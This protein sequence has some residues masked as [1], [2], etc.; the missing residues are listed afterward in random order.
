MGGGEKS[1][2]AARQDI[3]DERLGFTVESKGQRMCPLVGSRL[4]EWRRRVCLVAQCR[5]VDI[6]VSSVN[7]SVSSLSAMFPIC[8]A[9]R[10]GVSPFS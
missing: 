9:C 2:E 8:A 10:C 7:R 1:I 5:L 3:F 4:E 6:R